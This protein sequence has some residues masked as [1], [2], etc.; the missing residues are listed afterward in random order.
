MAKKPKRGAPTIDMTAMVDVAFLLLT[1]FILTTTRFREEEKVE[2][3]TPSSVSDLEVQDEKLMTVSIGSEGQVFVGFTD[4]STREG[5]LKLLMQEKEKAIS[6]DG[7]RYFSTL[8]EFGVK[9][10][11]I[12]SW[13]NEEGESSA[14]ESFTLESYPHEGIPTPDP[15]SA[16][17]E[18]PNELKEWIRWGRLTDQRMRFAIKGDVDTQYEIVSNVI[19]SLQDWK[20][21]QFSLI[22]EQEDG[23]GEEEE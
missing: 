15:D 9:I 3:D 6:E 5:V 18:N 16:T 7:A 12:D 2:V 1:F 10:D 14:G 22:T 23:E 4:I 20:I 19:S 21:N 17:V 11:E 13:L 8:Q